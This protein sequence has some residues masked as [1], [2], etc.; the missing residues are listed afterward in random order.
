LIKGR[1]GGERRQVEEKDKKGEI[2]N[3]RRERKEKGGVGK[4]VHGREKVVRERGAFKGIPKGKRE[5]GKG[6]RM[7]HEI[8]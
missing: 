1:G 6:E 3:E 4:K 7:D 5:K 8:Q 2:T